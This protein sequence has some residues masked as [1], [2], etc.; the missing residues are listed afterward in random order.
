[1][2]E[3]QNNRTIQ[4][5]GW[6]EDELA[7]F[8]DIQRDICQMKAAAVSWDD[9]MKKF[10]LRSLNNITT[11]INETIQGNIWTPGQITGGRP[12][13][14]SDVDIYIFKKK[15]NQAF[16]DLDCINTKEALQIVL[17]LKDFRY[18]RGQFLAQMTS[19]KIT[20]PKTTLET[21]NNMK[22]Y[23]P[24]VNWLYN[25][26]K[27]HEIIL[28]NPANLEEARKFYCNIAVINSFFQKNL[29][30]LNNTD[31]RLKFN[32]DE[33]SSIC[34]KK[35]RALVLNRSN[36]VTVPV[37]ANEP[38]ISTMLCYNAAGHRLRPFIII[39][40]RKNM[41]DELKD[42]EDAFI[43]SQS[44]GWMTTRLFSAYAVFFVAEINKY[45]LQLPQALRSQTIY[46]FV[47]NHLSRCNSFAIE[48]LRMHNIRLITFPAHCTHVIQPYDVGVASSFKLNM[49]SFRLSKSI[50]DKTANFND[51]AKARYITISSIINSWNSIPFE[52]LQKSFISC[53]LHP[54]NP[55]A[56]LLN[57]LTNPNCNAMGPRRRGTIDIT[58][59][60]LTSDANRLLIYNHEK[61]TNL[62]NASEIPSPTYASV[63][64]LLTSRHDRTGYI[65][66]ELPALL[67]KQPDGSFVDVL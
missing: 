53:G 65:L 23:I 35:F 50:R 9:I 18:I 63:R 58:N 5:F 57:P 37:P 22:T 52:V 27:E 31:P 60:E 21:L 1:M 16:C 26:C 39:P 56:V 10:H 42:I 44:S 4:V 17:E 55:S 38:H 43:T 2:N 61:G 54:F 67:I 62:A 51:T 33:T 6:T 30:I 45:R 24:S 20:L 3:Q 64:P 19:Q 25:F 14:L 34:S 28:K 29:A 46:L 59:Q 32:A 47:D 11:C 36:M 7:I 12:C 15:I 48:F 8:T 66:S 40:A 41:P 49:S 13:F